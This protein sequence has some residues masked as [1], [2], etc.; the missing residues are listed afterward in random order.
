MPER[1][2]QV[3]AD[4]FGIPSSEIPDN[5]SVGTLDGW[6]S[7]RHLELMLALESELGV[8]IPAEAMLEL[9]SLDAIVEYAAAHAA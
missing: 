5:A 6:D 7:L 3:L 4:V 8:P 1:V 9:L 2:K